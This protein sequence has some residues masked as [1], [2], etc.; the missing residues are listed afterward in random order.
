M[1]PFIMAPIPSKQ[2]LDRYR[3][4]TGDKDDHVLG[5]SIAVGA[6]FRITL[7]KP[8]LQAINHSNLSPKALTP[9]EFIKSILPNYIDYPNIRE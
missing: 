5:A 7:D 9:G 8:L 6:S 3:Q 4:A 1:T 2:Q